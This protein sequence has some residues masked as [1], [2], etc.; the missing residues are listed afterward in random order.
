M[1]GFVYFFKIIQ[2]PHL[3]KKKKSKNK[4]TK[5]YIYKIKHHITEKDYTQKTSTM[6]LFI[7]EKYLFSPFFFFSLR[8]CSYTNVNKP[9]QNSVH[10]R[11][12]DGTENV[13]FISWIILFF[14]LFVL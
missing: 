11:H 8:Q 6:L 13:G 3:Q 1:T 4:I 14:L 10:H 7:L 9:L 12:A 2:R 5:L